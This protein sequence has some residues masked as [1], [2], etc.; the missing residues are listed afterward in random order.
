M[1]EWRDIRE[2]EGYYQV[3]NYG[4]VR[5]LDRIVKG[6]R[7]GKEVAWH[8]KGKIL[9]QTNNE[10]EYNIVSISKK[11][12]KRVHVLVAEA[13]IPNPHGYTVVHHKNHDK[14]D[15]RV[16]NLMWMSFQQHSS[17]HSSEDS[18]NKRK[19]LSKRVD[20]IDML[21]GEVIHQWES[22]KEVEREL[23]YSH[24]I[25]SECCNGKRKSANGFVWKYVKR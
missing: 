7:N 21:T 8:R 25:I 24:G 15:N 4:R 10:N 20:Q 17:L 11:N 19:L 14:K 22:L 1:E 16:E 13:F 3:S 23:G 5:S 2:Y 6:V 18:D 12:N 9:N